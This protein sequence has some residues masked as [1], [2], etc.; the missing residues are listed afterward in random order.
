MDTCFNG[1]GFTL[2]T[3]IVCV[4][5]C[6]RSEFIHLA[7]TCR[8]RRAAEVLWKFMQKLLIIFRLS[9]WCYTRFAPSDYRGGRFLTGGE[10]VQII[11]PNNP[12][13]WRINKIIFMLPDLLNLN[14]TNNTFFKVRWM[15]SL[16]IR[17]GPPSETPSFIWLLYLL[18]HRMSELTPLLCNCVDLVN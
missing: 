18:S 3:Q 11:C 13:V 8:N 7:L 4:A 12:E 14:C 5:Q 10:S 9:G 2:K 1:D 15:P 16:L 17:P 6:N